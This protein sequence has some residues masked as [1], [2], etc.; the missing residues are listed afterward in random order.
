M[1]PL[2]RAIET[3]SETAGY[4]AGATVL[5]LTALIASAVIARRVFGSPIL[6]ADELSGYLLLTI[7]F[8]GLA[9]T[10]KAGGHIRADIVLTHVPV[11]VREALETFAIVLA[12]AFTLALLGGAWALVVEY[13]GHGTT[14]FKS[15][16]VP[17]WI[18]GALLVAGAALLELQLAAQLL[19]K[20]RG[21][22]EP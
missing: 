5:G 13:Y 4:L 14:S 21:Q 20:L 8:F 7:V 2:V 18:P 10:M 11:K 17:L 22:P 16:Q 19:R 9:H 6:A 3:L 1:R 15:L 12:L